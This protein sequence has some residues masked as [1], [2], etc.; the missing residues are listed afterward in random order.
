MLLVDYLLTELESYQWFCSL[1]AASEIWAVMM[2]ERARLMSVFVCALGNFEWLCMPFG[3]KLAPMI[4]QQLVDNAL[5]EYVQPKVGWQEFAT[6][7]KVAEDKTASKRS[8]KTTHLNEFG[9]VGSAVTDLEADY[10]ALDESDPFQRLSMTRQ[11]TRSSRVSI[12][13]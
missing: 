9:S 5:W 12:D 11:A 2:T 3:L 10:R 13:N 4:Y 1:D 7:I 6:K 8:A